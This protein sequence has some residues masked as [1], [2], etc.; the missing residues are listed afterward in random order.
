MRS[1]I[2]WRRRPTNQPMPHSTQSVYMMVAQSVY[3]CAPHAP[4]LWARLCGT[5]HTHFHCHHHANESP[6]CCVCP[7]DGRWRATAAAAAAVALVARDF[8]GRRTDSLQQIVTLASITVCSFSFETFV[9]KNWEYSLP[10]SRTFL[11]LFI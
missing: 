6:A 5:V 10:H 3:K 9:I 4:Y 8:S 1:S 7:N 2:A 11:P